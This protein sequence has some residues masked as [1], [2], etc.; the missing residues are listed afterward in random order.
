MKVASK[1]NSMYIFTFSISVF[2]ASEMY[3]NVCIDNVVV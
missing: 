1:I 2:A 3:D